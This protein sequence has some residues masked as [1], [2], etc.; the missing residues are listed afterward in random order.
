MYFGFLQDYVKII[1]IYP[2]TKLLELFMKHQIRLSLN[3]INYH[4][5][6]FL[7]LSMTH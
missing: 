4:L 7:Q 2:F 1:H 5:Q 3:K 6:L